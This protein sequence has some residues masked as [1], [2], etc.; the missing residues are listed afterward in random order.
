MDTGGCHPFT[1][2]TYE[3]L[4]CSFILCTYL[5]EHSTRLFGAAE[6]LMEAVGAPVYKYVKV[7]PSL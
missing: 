3:Q 2:G 7:D 6:G 5:A 4:V 1:Y